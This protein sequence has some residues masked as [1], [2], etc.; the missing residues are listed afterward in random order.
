MTQEDIEIIA[1]TTCGTYPTWADY[2]I[3]S[4]YNHVDKVVVVNG[5]YDIDHPEKRTIF[6]LE[7]EHNKIKEIDINN[8]IIETIPNQQDIDNIFKTTCKLGKDE[9]GRSTNMT[10]S[11]QIAT[12]LPNPNNKKRWILKLD[13]DQ[14]LYR[15]TRR[16]LTDLILQYPDKSGFRFAQYAGFFN[17]FKHADYIPDEFTNDGAL[18]YQSLPDQGYCGQGSPGYIKVDQYPIY[19][20]K[21]A[22]M[23]RIN[24]PGVDPYEYHYK[25]LWYHTYG[26][27]SIMEH[28]HNRKTGQKLTNEQIKEIAHNSAMSTLQNKGIEISSH[29]FDERIPYRPPLVCEIGPLEYIR[30]LY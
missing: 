5:G 25:R 22:H 26:P 29:P 2:T 20:I 4:F 18:L 21:T 9:Y 15:I 23:R 1:S 30:R 12:N 13:S 11:T 10:L 19:S 3:A 14:I 24:P 27:N 17:D 8:K 28:E 7:R 6:P 16:Q